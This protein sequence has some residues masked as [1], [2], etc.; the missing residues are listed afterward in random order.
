M[1]AVLCL[2]GKNALMSLAQGLGWPR[3][4]V[5][6]IF[7]DVFLKKEGTK[8]G[9]LGQTNSRMHIRQGSA[10]M[11]GMCFCSTAVPQECPAEL[12]ITAVQCHLTFLLSQK[13]KQQC[14]HNPVI[15]WLHWTGFIGGTAAPAGGEGGVPDLM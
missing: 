4:S 3:S 9:L 10:T 2:Q 11:M 13:D 15:Q 8:A 7:L 1:Q 12:P 5:V 14:N 6:G